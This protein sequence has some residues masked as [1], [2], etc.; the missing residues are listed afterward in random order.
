MASFFLVLAA[1]Q[2]AAPARSVSPVASTIPLAD[3]I[4]GMR[5]KAK[6]LESSSGM[7]QGF[8]SFTSEYKLTLT[9]VN[10]SDFA[11][12]RLVYEAARDA[13]FWNMHWN[14]TN[15]PPNSDSVWRQWRGV[16]AP[17]FVA[18][19]AT[20]ECD[21]LSALYAFLVE[22]AGVRTIG[23][24]WPYPNHTV[25]V[26]VLHPAGG[27]AIRVVVPT[28]QIFLDETDDFGTQKFNPWTQ[29]TIYEYTRRDAPDNFKLP[30][31]LCDFF[32]LQMDKYGGATNATLQRL[33]YLR[34]AVF[35][36]TWPRETAANEA[37]RYRASL[38]HPSPEDIRALEA[39][40]QDMGR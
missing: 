16:E 27:P 26:W 13:G 37:L 40:A 19:T 10:Y 39:F 24:F 32:L 5:T 12:V 30:K 28:S 15:Q 35:L 2:G 36:N 9:S 38:S 31:P 22:R 25:A 29:K 23:L 7:H 8:E 1:S 18:P 3:F 33:R 17:S 20:A 11:V 34:E 21:E 14:I 4:G 6:T